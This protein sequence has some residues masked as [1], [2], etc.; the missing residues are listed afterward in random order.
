MQAQ[1]FW[2]ADWHVQPQLNRIHGDNGTVQI[3]PRIMDVLVL[4]AQTPGHVV[5]REE[6]LEAVW[7]NRF[8]GEEALTRS[9]SELRKVFGDNPRKPQ[10]IETIRKSGYRLIAPVRPYVKPPKPRTASSPAPSV[11]TPASWFSKP[12]PYILATAALVLLIGAMLWWTTRPPLAASSPRMVPLTSYPGL[13]RQPMLSP[14]G[15]QVAFVWGGTEAN[16][17]IYIKLVGG[18]Q[19]LRL[20]D[21]PAADLHP[22]WS[23]DGKQVAFARVT[24]STCAIYSKPALGGPE[25]RLTTCT[26]GSRPTP[27]W[28]PDGQWLVYNDRPSPTAPYRLVRFSFAT[29]DTLTLTHPPTQYAGDTHPLFSPNALSSQLA[30][31]RTN[32]FGIMDLFLIDVDGEHLKRLTFDHLKIRG[33][34]WDAG[35][36][37]IIY[38]SNRTG[39]FNLWR[40]GTEGGEPDVFH[41]SDH[42]HGLS[43]AEQHSRLVHETW[44]VDINVWGIPLAM[45]ESP[46]AHR[47]LTST[48]WDAFG[49]YSPDAE[50]LAFASTRSGT[51]ELWMSDAN[52]SNLVRL[53]SFG[54]PYTSDPQWSPQGTRIAFASRAHGNADL[55]MLDPEGGLPQRLTT[56]PSIDVNP[57]WSHNGNWLYFASN[58]SGSWQLWKLAVNGTDTV[59]V[60]QDG[61]YVARES[62]DG[63][64]L[65]YTRFD[66]PGLWRRTL[67][68][69]TRT[70]LIPDFRQTYNL[71]W[72]LAEDT[73]YYINTSGTPH[74]RRFDLASQT[75]T[76]VYTFSKEPTN[77]GLSISPDGNMLLFSQ[78]DFQE[79]DLTLL[80][81]FQP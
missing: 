65:Y 68:D 23:P 79:S 15:K 58:R 69:T 41:I 6:L 12:I 9:I 49:T 46:S 35:G 11:A 33:L 7:A 5:R 26:A 60:T 25:R 24:D 27:T 64:A 18:E 50:R 74:I 32:I 78:L 67:S 21:H 59:Q 51:P 16:E 63:K 38:S 80:E 70:L 48:R 19:P 77:S 20:T 55:Y 37:H 30:F 22:T 34:T 73:I 31:T 57:A 4:L 81:H 8:V 1:E 71:A 42:I 76:H 75:S 2:I 40:I 36:E 10:V 56:N 3:E 43:Y 45:P 72:T 13:E 17:D 62:L 14:D 52:G 28:S 47:V 44:Q 66:Q 61:G 29:E 54:G 39:L 53:T